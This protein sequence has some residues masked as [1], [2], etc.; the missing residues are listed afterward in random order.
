MIRQHETVLAVFDRILAMTAAL[1]LL[2]IMRA[3]MALGVSA[4]TEHRRPHRASPL[5]TMYSVARTN[6]AQ[7]GSE[8]WPVMTSSQNIRTAL[9]MQQA[10]TYSITLI[11]LLIGTN[12]DM[13][14]LMLQEI[15]ISPFI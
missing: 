7:K 2:A 15:K 6:H 3:D 9:S 14:H 13:R 8:E 12:G 1:Q 10:L 4:R 11:T 5:S